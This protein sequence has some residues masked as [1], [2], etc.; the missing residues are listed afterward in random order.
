MVEVDAPVPVT[1]EHGRVP[2]A[3]VFEGRRQLI[4]YFHM[5]HPGQPAPGQCEGCTFFN[6]QVSELF[7]PGRL[8]PALGQ[9]R[10]PVP[11][12]GPPQP[13]MATPGR[14]PVRR[15]HR[16]PAALTGAGG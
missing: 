13:A 11:H 16:H 2:L 5:W 15:P 14:P 3:E 6:G 9:Q 1:G 12:P 10:R 8:A 4:A 7:Y